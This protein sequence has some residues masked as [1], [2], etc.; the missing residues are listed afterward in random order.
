ML[1][2][3]FHFLNPSKFL[4]WLWYFDL[5]PKLNNLWLADSA[6]VREILLTEMDRLR[7]YNLSENS[8]EASKL[9][10]NSKLC[11]EKSSCSVVY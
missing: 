6:D 1:N 9:D 8:A 11:L 3:L 7:K 2:Q 5:F 4:P 10:I